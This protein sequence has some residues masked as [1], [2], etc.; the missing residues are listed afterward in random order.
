LPPQSIDS[1]AK[2]GWWVEFDGDSAAVLELAERATEVIDP[3]PPPMDL[4]SIF[5]RSV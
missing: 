5:D 4:A 2:F 1:H 3:R